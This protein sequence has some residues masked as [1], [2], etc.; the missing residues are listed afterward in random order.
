MF[1][2]IDTIVVIGQAISLNFP[3]EEK[4]KFIHCGGYKL[5]N[6]RDYLNYAPNRGPEKKKVEGEGD[7]VFEN[8]E[9]LYDFCGKGDIKAL[10]NDVSTRK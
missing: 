6:E 1:K 3:K 8:I 4:K 5:M 10:G 7:A 2:S 9:E